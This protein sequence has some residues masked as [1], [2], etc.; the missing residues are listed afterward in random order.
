MVGGEDLSCFGRRRLLRCGRAVV[1]SCNPGL[2]VVT[3]ARSAWHWGPMEGAVASA[4][5]GPAQLV[6]TLPLH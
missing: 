2:W 6:D 4:W 1:T 3:L 5:P